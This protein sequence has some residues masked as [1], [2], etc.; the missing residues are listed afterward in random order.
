M[1][2]LFLMFKWIIGLVFD[3]CK[4]KCYVLNFRFKLLVVLIML[5]SG[6]YLF[7]MCF[8]VVL[9]FFSLLLILL[10]DGNVLIC[11]FIIFVSVCFFIYIN[12]VINN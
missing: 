7:V 6:W 12:L 8:S 4:L 1:L 5:V 11:V 3:L 2:F 9:V 10:E